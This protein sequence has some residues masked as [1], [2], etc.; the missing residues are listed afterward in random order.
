MPRPLCRPGVSVFVLFCTGK[1]SKLSTSVRQCRD[2]SAVQAP[3]GQLNECPL[4]P[5][6]HAHCRFLFLIPLLQLQAYTRVCHTHH[7]ARRPVAALFRACCAYV[8]YCL[9][10]CILY[11]YKY[12][13]LYIHIYIHVIYV[14]YIYVI[15][16]CYIYILYMLYMY[17]V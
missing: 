5:L 4:Q 8:L 9:C 6:Q 17:I 7:V 12:M 11:I 13:S 10:I 14:C 1:A 2:P 3:P 15:Y 16:I